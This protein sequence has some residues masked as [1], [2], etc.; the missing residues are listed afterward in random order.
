MKIASFKPVGPVPAAN[1]AAG[2]SSVPRGGASS[3]TGPKPPVADHGDYNLDSDSDDDDTS[4]AT[5]LNKTPFDTTPEN[6]AKVHETLLSRRS[7]ERTE[8]DD[9]DRSSESDSEEGGT[10]FDPV[11]LKFD[12]PTYPDSDTTPRSDALRNLRRL[13]QPVPPV[14]RLAFSAAAD[15]QSPR[16]DAG[17]HT[18]GNVTPTVTPRADTT[19]RLADAESVTGSAAAPPPP[20]AAAQLA[21]TALKANTQ[22]GAAATPR[23]ADA[24]NAA[25]PLAEAR[26]LPRLPVPPAD[27]SSLSYMPEA[28]AAPL[29]VAPPHVTTPP[30][31]ADA[32]TA[33][34]RATT[35]QLAAT[36][37]VSKIPLNSFSVPKFLKGPLSSRRWIGQSKASPDAALKTS[38]SSPTVTNTTALTSPNLVETQ[39]RLAVV[40]PPVTTPPAAAAGLRTPALL[41]SKRAANPHT[42]QTILVNSRRGTGTPPQP[43]AVGTTPPVN[44]SLLRSVFSHLFP[45]ASAIRM[46]SGR[47]TPQINSVAATSQDSQALNKLKGLAKIHGRSYVTSLESQFEVVFNNSNSSE[48][49]YELYRDGI[50]IE[51]VEESNAFKEKLDSFGRSSNDDDYIYDSNLAT[52]LNVLIPDSIKEKIKEKIDELLSTIPAIQNQ[53][54]TNAITKNYKDDVKNRLTIEYAGFLS[55]YSSCQHSV[56]IAEREEFLNKILEINEEENI[57][58]ILKALKNLSLDN[59]ASKEDRRLD[60]DLNIEEADSQVSIYKI[61]PKIENGRVEAEREYIN[62]KKIAK[63]IATEPLEGESKSDKE[64]P[65]DLVHFH[66]INN[67]FSGGDQGF[68]VSD[69]NDDKKNKAL[70]IFHAHKDSSANQYSYKQSIISGEDIQKFEDTI[71]E[72]QKY[73]SLLKKDATE[74]KTID[75]IK[76][77]YED[78]VKAY[79]PGQV[80]DE[81]SQ[82]IASHKKLA[83][84]LVA[85]DFLD[86]Q[87]FSDKY[88]SKTSD[89]PLN[90]AA[91]SQDSSSSKLQND[92]DKKF[93]DIAVPYKQ[94]HALGGIFQK[95]ITISR[96]QDEVSNQGST[97]SAQEADKFVNV[98]NVWDESSLDQQKSAFVAIN[99]PP[100][101]ISVKGENINATFFRK[102]AFTKEGEIRFSENIYYEDGS[103]EKKFFKIKE[104]DESDNKKTLLND[105]AALKIKT[106]YVAMNKN[107]IKTLDKSYTGFNKDSLKFFNNNYEVKQPAADIRSAA[108]RNVAEQTNP[109]RQ[110]GV[111]AGKGV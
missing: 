102:I 29:A 110:G 23:L 18:P 81:E 107:E 63:R 28:A 31:A 75:Q 70:I 86:C 9:S 105:L 73:I 16:A 15:S 58:K 48:G 34:Q 42:P 41:L 82:T 11:I 90:Q 52:S 51:D 44:T 95:G 35:P 32:D 104:I 97:E 2:A 92:L 85:Q 5:D 49:E 4:V 89:T 47:R 59:L 25:A 3:G 88:I 84:A 109:L 54:Q 79:I 68:S 33:P 46:F 14:G 21:T 67:Y 98:V 8:E 1:P 37:K 69:S 19:P 93:A 17:P 13:R 38:L 50:K 106:T 64:S 27:S 24:E 57:N 99:N 83:I 66:L 40:P 94:Y 30:A 100:Y 78:G 72:K 87:V 71:K 80:I 61:H 62:F 103:G 36:T 12:S 6:Q 101:Q 53:T 55:P 10:D 7:Q 56:T 74:E 65:T 77:L 111:A 60:L 108:S 91:L 96:H 22:V 26:N 20:A 45:A 39:T 76:K 43:A